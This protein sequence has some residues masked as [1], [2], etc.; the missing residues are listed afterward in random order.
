MSEEFHIELENFKG[1][2]HILL[3][4]IEK[5]KLPINEISLSKISDEF[6]KRASKL[7]MS[8]SAYSEFISLASTLMLIKSKTLLPAEERDEE[9]EESVELQARLKA[10]Q[11][12]KQESQKTKN[13]YKKQSIF[14]RSDSQIRFKIKF[15]YTTPQKFLK[16]LGRHMQ[17]ILSKLPSFSE[18][19]QIVRRKIRSLEEVLKDIEHKLNEYVK[20]AF[21]E[22]D[23]KSRED[24]LVAFL[25][26]L[27]LR[28]KG[29]VQV[30]QKDND[31]H[32]EQESIEM[33]HYG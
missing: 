20:I 15:Q 1:P 19:V 33:P 11:L 13:L 3:E 31:I 23:I 9:D 28:R 8:K 14:R 30:V 21:S 7:A 12:L 10:L 6:L 27:E 18:K 5:H 4:L 25:A 29:K 22:L 16:T 2:L 24:K 32:I 26:V 17:D